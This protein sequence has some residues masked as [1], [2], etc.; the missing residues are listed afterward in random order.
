M[1]SH[2]AMVLVQ[3]M[4]FHQV[5]PVSMCGQLEVGDFF[6]NQVQNCHQDFSLLYQNSRRLCEK[7]ILAES[8]PST[9]FCC[10]LGIIWADE[11]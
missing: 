2:P 4:N 3:M 9:E 8:F 5:K 6:R 1:A 7:L 10:I 11:L